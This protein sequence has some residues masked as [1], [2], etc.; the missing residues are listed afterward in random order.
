MAP[1]AATYKA[2]PLL[3]ISPLCFGAISLLDPAKFKA[4]DWTVGWLI[5]GNFS[6]NV[7]LNIWFSATWGILWV[8]KGKNWLMFVI[9]PV[10]TR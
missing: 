4:P 6:V 5:K 3:S 9:V 7:V 1:L 8:N 2:W 10:L